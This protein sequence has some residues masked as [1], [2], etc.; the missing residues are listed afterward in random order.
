[1]LNWV[2]NRTKT[3]GDSP[4]RQQNMARMGVNKRRISD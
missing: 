1:M 4:V 3:S 2:N